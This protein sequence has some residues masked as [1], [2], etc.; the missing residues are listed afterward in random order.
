[1]F[2]P[3]Y[4]LEQKRNV[5]QMSTRVTKLLILAGSLT[6]VSHC[7]LNSYLLLLLVLEDIEVNASLT[8]LLFQTP[9]YSLLLPRKRYKCAVSMIWERL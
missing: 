5:K 4:L 8:S 1:M 7:Y 6:H 2:V 9:P 3:Q